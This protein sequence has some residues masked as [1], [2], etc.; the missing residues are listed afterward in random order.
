MCLI[1]LMVDG[2]RLPFFLLFDYLSVVVGEKSLFCSLPFRSCILPL[3]L[4]LIFHLSLLPC[5]PFF[6]LPAPGLRRSSY[7]ER[8]STHVV[9]YIRKIW[10]S[11]ERLRLIR[12]VPSLP[13]PY[14]MG[15]R[16]SWHLRLSICA[17]L[18]PETGAEWGF[19]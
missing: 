8:N 13:L 4:F 15:D 19:S 1:Y 6:N 5:P 10:R 2:D 9:L 16:K 18:F 3:L 12:Q 17:S 14:P 11:W 7:T